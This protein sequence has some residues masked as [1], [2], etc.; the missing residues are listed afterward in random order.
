MDPDQPHTAA[1]HGYLCGT[2]YNFP[3]IISCG[4]MKCI[5]SGDIS[6]KNKHY[7]F[8]VKKD[9]VGL[10]TYFMIFFCFISHAHLFQKASS[11]LSS[12]HHI[13]IILILFGV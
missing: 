8:Y 11:Y 9:L 2:K 13:S 6:K 7:I 1:D 5:I 12:T 10:L 4:G 3:G